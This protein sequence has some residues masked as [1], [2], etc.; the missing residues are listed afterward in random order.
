LVGLLLEKALTP[1]G[2]F[3]EPV[4]SIFGMALNALIGDK[5]KEACELTFLDDFEDRI[6]SALGGVSP[7]A[8][9]LSKVRRKIGSKY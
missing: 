7:A 4:L 9:R 6:F 3:G 1:V 5:I 8:V 2:A